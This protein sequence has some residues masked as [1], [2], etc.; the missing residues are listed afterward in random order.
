MRDE[1][2][3]IQLIKETYPLEPR[4]EFVS[5][6]G[7]VLKK[8]ANQRRSRL[9]YKNRILTSL[10]ITLCAILASWLFFFDGTAT[11]KQNMAA[12]V[13]DQPSPPAEREEPS[14]YIYHSHDKES[15]IPEI[16]ANQSSE[17]FDDSTNITLVGKRL[18][19][20][21]NERGINTIHEQISV[22]DVLDKRQWSFDQSYVVSRERFQEV[23]KDHTKVK[24][25]LD[26]HRDSRKKPETTLTVENKEYA[27]MMF[28]VSKSSKNFEENLRFANLLHKKI[29]KNM[30]GLST[31]VLVKSK[32]NPDEQNTYNQD[33]LE[34]SV[35]MN[36]GGEENTL[37]EEYRTI[38]VLAEI[39]ADIM[40]K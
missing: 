18:H 11:V 21:L 31:G 24:M 37:E 20:L 6:T 3:I 26:I 30:P 2:E 35:L 7:Q 33:L 10:G 1:K 13:T 16:S 8:A 14:I 40:K 12:L 28:I 4:K 38:E 39:I 9:Q 23:L 15:F 29:E 34:Q 17:A 5:A 27:R 25:A 22:G 36:V 32:E 19:Q